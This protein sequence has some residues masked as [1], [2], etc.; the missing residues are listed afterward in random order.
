MSRSFKDRADVRELE[1]Y[2]LVHHRIET[3]RTS[4]DES[5]SAELY[6]PFERHIADSE[7]VTQVN[8]SMLLSNHP[9]A[10]RDQSSLSVQ[11]SKGLALCTR[12]F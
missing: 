12:L 1:H 11:Y 8:A 10:L 6:M 2:R 5:L 7:H 3:M 4:P 9:S